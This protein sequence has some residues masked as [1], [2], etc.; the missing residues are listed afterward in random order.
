[1]VTAVGTP[2]HVG[3]ATQVWDIRLHDDR[4]RPVCV[5]RCT[6][7]IVPLAV[8]SGRDGALVDGTRAAEGRG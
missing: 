4:G 2:L 3:R 5:S 8:G 1:M 7:A 6:I